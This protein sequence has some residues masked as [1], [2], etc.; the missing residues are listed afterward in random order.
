MLVFMLYWLR[1][2]LIGAMAL[3][4]VAGSALACTCGPPMDGR[5]PSQQAF[6]EAS[7]VGLVTLIGTKYAPRSSTCDDRHRL[8]DCK[9]EKMG[10]FRV[11]RTLK[12][13]SEAS[14][15]ISLEYSQCMMQGL[16]RIGEQAWIAAFGDPEI[17][18]FFGDCRWFEPP[19]EWNGDPVAEN[20]LR[21]QGRRDSLE[22]AARHRPDPQAL[23]ELAKF[24]AQTRSRLEAISVLDQVLTADRLHPEANI[25]RAQLLAIG[26]RQQAVIASIAP[27]LTAHPDDREAMHQHVLALVRLDR[28]SEVPDDWRDFTGL[29]GLEYD[30]S[31][32]ALDGSSFRGDIIY[33]TSFVGSNLRNSDFSEAHLRTSDFSGADLTGAILVK[34][35]LEQASFQRAVLDGADLSGAYLSRADFRGASL[36]GAVLSQASLG[37]IQYDEATIWPEGFKPD[38]AGTQ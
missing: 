24:L 7:F 15:R 30:F 16:Y 1:R 13:S 12:G 4:A 8:S 38:G 37:G 29:H 6:D 9:P 19:S 27:Y 36:K 35:Q 31:N 17:G 28:L 21:Y 11:E 32:R 20:V 34:T 3:T 25:L 22:A 2:L 23:M 18:Y 5:T 33:R 26:P 10:I 14:L